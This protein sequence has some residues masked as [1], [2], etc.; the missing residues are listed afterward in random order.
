MK[1][2]NKP[3]Y[4]PVCGALLLTV[5]S[6]SAQNMYVGSYG[7]GDVVEVPTSGSPT[8]IG[9]NLQYPDGLAFNNSGTTLF[10]ANQ[11]GGDILEYPAAGGAPTTF[12]QSLNNPSALAFNSAGDLFVTTGANSI[13]EY[14][15]GGGTPTTFASGLDNCAGIAFDKSGD[16]F[17]AD[18]GNGDSGNITEFYAGGGKNVTTPV[19]NPLSIAFQ[20]TLPVPEPSTLAL[21]AVG[22]A[23]FLVRRRK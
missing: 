18:A 8:V 3:Y 20:G 11:L 6:A 12:A 17:V 7:G 9:N 10:V 21:A 22:A 16:L 23:A 14:G 19:S 2:Q 1:T 13:L 15:P 4:Y 5:L